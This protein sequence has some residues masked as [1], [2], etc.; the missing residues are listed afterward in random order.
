MPIIGLTTGLHGEPLWKNLNIVP[1]RIT[2]V[3]PEENLGHFLKIQ[4]FFLC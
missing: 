4:V 1:G 2:T 3:G